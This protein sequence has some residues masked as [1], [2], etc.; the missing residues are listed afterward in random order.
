MD[1]PSQ[2][3]GAKSYELSDFTIF[4]KSQKKS[5]TKNMSLFNWKYYTVKLLILK[6]VK[7]RLHP[8]CLVHLHNR[9]HSGL[10]AQVSHST[11][12]CIELIFGTILL[13]TEE[14]EN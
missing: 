7:K 10:E 12:E 13:G 14:F 5:D 8:L 4:R 3:R 6:C 1:G 11:L 2:H 9:C